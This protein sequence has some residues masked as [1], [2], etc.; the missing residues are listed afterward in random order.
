[1]KY[2]NKIGVEIEGDFDTDFSDRDHTG[3][4]IHSDGSIDINGAEN[5]IECVTDPCTSRREIRAV[6]RKIYRHLNSVNNSCGLHIHISVKKNEDYMCLFSYSFAKF[7]YD[8]ALQL[9][10]TELTE[11]FANRFCTMFIDELDFR[12]NAENQIKQTDKSSCRYFALNYC[13]NLHETIE[14]RFFNAVQTV[15]DAML[16]VDFLCDCIYYFLETTLIKKN[17]R[18]KEKEKFDTDIVAEKVEIE[19]IQMKTESEIYV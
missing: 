19:K 9:K 16:Y 6:L 11:R 15:E 12:R 7:I 1:M 17:F 5:E 8:K 14:V 4:E 10:K 13:R 2:I 18:L 3:F